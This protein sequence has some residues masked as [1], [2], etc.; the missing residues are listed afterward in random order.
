MPAVRVDVDK[1]TGLSPLFKFA[2]S[3]KGKFALSPEEMATA[4]T[5]LA[6]SDEFS[7]MTGMYI[8]EK[9]RSVQPPNYARQAENI[10]AVTHLTTQYLTI[11][12]MTAATYSVRR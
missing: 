7:A 6:T 4:Y 1:Y 3:L 10:E 9:L 12:A 2:Y 11:D 5:A 8:D